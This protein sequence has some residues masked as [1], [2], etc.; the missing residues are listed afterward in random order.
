MPSPS[1]D[2][3][4]ADGGIGHDAGQGPG[5]ALMGAETLTGNDVYSRQAEKLREVKEVM[6]DMR[7]GRISYAVLSFGGVPGRGEKLFAIPRALTLDTMNKRFMLDVDKAQLAR[8]PGFDKNT[9]P[10]MAN[11]EWARGSTPTTVAPCIRCK[12]ADRCRPWGR[13]GSPMRPHPGRP[14]EHLRCHLT[15]LAP[16]A[17]CAPAAGCR[18]WFRP[19]GLDVPRSDPPKVHFPDVES[20]VL[21]LSRRFGSTRLIP[22]DMRA[23]F[24]LSCVPRGINPT[25]WLSYAL[26]WRVC[27]VQAIHQ[28]K[29]R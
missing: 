28:A 10:D 13:V 24:E 17:A 12:A 22:H 11:S 1:G 7:G 4:G 8:A 21:P 15:H 9:W 25:R 16:N 20:P 14:R 29:P 27:H 18:P 23:R 6:P 19:Q 5:P 3:S 2:W 26:W